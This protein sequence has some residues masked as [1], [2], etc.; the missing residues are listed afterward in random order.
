M[1]INSHTYYSLRYGTLSPEELVARVK[2]AGGK[3]IVLTDINNTSATYQFI[4]TCRE[5]GIKPIAGIEFREDNEFLYL[6]IAKNKERVQNWHH[7]WTENITRRQAIAWW[8]SWFSK[9]LCRL[10]KSA[11]GN[12]S[13][14]GKWIYRYQTRRGK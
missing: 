3:E 10:Q 13:I 4:M 8:S 6:G 2:E 9:C 7:F 1:Y 11:K 5:N 14:E 12:I